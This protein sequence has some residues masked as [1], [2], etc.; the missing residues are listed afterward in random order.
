M[1]IFVNGHEFGH[2]HYNGKDRF[3]KCRLPLRIGVTHIKD[4]VQTTSFIGQIDEV[5]VWN[6]A[7]TEDEIRSDMNI[8]LNGDEP[9][10]GWILEI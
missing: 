9:G 2:R 4:Q 5:R 8:Q 10:F 1:K 3:V 6:L 7:R